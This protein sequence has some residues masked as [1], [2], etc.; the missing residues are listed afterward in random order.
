MFSKISLEAARLHPQG[1]AILML[2][3]GH[4]RGGVGRTLDETLEA[5][6]S[7]KWL[8]AETRQEVRR[9]EVFSLREL[10][11]QGFREQ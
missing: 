6:S 8:R 10:R 9:M 7:N 4:D 2:R 11:E 5:L 3:Y 1:R